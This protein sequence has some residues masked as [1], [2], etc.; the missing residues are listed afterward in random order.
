MNQTQELEGRSVWKGEWHVMS[1]GLE[2]GLRRPRNFLAELFPL[3]LLPRSLHTSQDTPLTSR[4]SFLQG[5]PGQ[6][7]LRAQGGP[8]KVHGQR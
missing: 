6:P 8:Q 5:P 3:S 1:K 2:T 7:G 4:A